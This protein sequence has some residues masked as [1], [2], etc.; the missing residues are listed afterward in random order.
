[1]NDFN[2]HPL[3]QE[4]FVREVWFDFNSASEKTPSLKF[5][6]LKK[7]IDIHVWIEVTFCYQ[8]NDTSNCFV[9]IDEPNI[10]LHLDDEWIA[11]SKASVGSLRLLIRIL[12]R[13]L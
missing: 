5:I 12:N 9:R 6:S 10:E 8:K 4:G 1:M 11:L 13:M 3:E 2:E 7:K